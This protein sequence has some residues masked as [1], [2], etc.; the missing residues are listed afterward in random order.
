[1]QP[2]EPTV[3][4]ELEAA[5]TRLTGGRRVV[6]GAGRTDR[7]VHA[8]GQVA[9]VD[10]PSRWDASSLRKALNAVLPRDIWVADVRPA[11]PRFH[12]RFDAVERHYLYRV[13]L[14]EESAS[15]FH[16][17]WCWPLRR[18]LDR[19]RL[20]AGASM[21]PGEHSFRSFARSGQEERGDRCTV[22]YAEWEE[23][24]DL[25]VGFRIGANRFLHHMVR[26]LVGT[27]VAI[28]L[29]ERPVEDIRRLLE[30]EPQLRTSPPAPAAGLFLT[31]VEYPP[32]ALDPGVP[33]ASGETFSVTADRDEST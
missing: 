19:E 15:P 31:R 20:E 27:M 3:Q 13:G 14:A 25:G 12:P 1:M 8:T 5:L 29:E 21:L 33:S 6:V 22:L 2:V 30:N 18:P 9:S 24:G 10:V 23:W 16:R 11:A 4:G 17:P 26:Y 32:E 7:G 28:G